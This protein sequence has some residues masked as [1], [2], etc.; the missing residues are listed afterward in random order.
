MRILAALL[1][2]AAAASAGLGLPW[3]LLGLALI[4]GLL[5]VG[6]SRQQAEPL[7]AEEVIATIYQRAGRL[8]LRRRRA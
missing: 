5:V 7:P 3:L 6:S 2:L 1:L 8:V 4:L